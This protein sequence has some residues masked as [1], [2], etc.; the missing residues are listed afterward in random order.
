[1]AKNRWPFLGRNIAEGSHRCLLSTA[2]K[3]N[4]WPYEWPEVIEN[5]T[6]SDLLVILIVSFKAITSPF[7]F[8]LANE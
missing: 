8:W 4:Y 6:H 7:V 1:M 2:N 5:N 3:L